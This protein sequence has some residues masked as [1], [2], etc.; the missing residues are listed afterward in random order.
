MK[1]NIVFIGLMGAGKTTV[2]RYLANLWAM[3]FA[4]F[5]KEI[6]KQEKMSVSE[7]FAQKGEKYFR[8]MEKVTI[9]RFMDCNNFIISTGGGIVKDKENIDNLKKI[10]KVIY[11][12]APVK[13]IYERIKN[14]DERPLLKCANPLLELENIFKQRSKL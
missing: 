8:Q 2:G 4:D 12:K 1:N 5:D 6:A 7:I 3:N 13:V 9:Q 11:L 10:G 14:N